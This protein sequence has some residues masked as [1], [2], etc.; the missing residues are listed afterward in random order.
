MVM[1]RASA[2]D[3]CSALILPIRRIGASG[4]LE[5]GHEASSL[6][7]GIDERLRDFI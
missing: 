4:L 2:N 1:K 5:L 7:A 3:G 6:D